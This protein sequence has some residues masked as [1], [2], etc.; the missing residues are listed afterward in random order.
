MLYQSGGVI[1][2][3]DPA[4]IQAALQ[5]LLACFARYRTYHAADEP[6]AHAS[7]LIRA[8]HA[9][10]VARAADDAI[11]RR[12]LDFVADVLASPNPEALA[13]VERLQQLMPT[14]QAKGIEDTASYRYAR[15]LS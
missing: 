7:R 9:E 11:E 3:M 4:A 8:A 6:D 14:V 12:A 5:V 10:A 15:L 13:A 2:A 1:S